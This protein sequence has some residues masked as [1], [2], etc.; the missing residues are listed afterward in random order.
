MKK[1]WYSMALALLLLIG[2]LAGC[3]RAGL[4]SGSAASTTEVAATA[5]ATLDSSTTATG[6]LETGVRE[7]AKT[8]TATITLSPAAGY[9]GTF[10][11][12]SGA[13]WPP[14]ALVVVKLADA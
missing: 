11:D 2:G 8:G 3:A 6:T 4:G 9:A 12:V 1:S 14:S 10:V 7:A 13:G 5:V